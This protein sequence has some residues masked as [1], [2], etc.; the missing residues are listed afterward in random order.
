[1]SQLYPYELLPHISDYVTFNRLIEIESP[2]LFDIKIDIKATF[3]SLGKGQAGG[4]EYVETNK[5]LI[6]Y[7][8]YNNIG[9]YAIFGKEEKE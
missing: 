1:M 5:K 8:V 6:Q 3:L 7:C 9:M 2:C 4:E